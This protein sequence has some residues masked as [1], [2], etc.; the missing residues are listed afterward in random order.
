MTAR[1][2]GAIL[3]SEG[4]REVLP[5]G[6][7]AGTLRGESGRGL[8]ELLV[9]VTLIVLTAAAAIPRAQSMVHESRLR[10]AAFYLRGL[11]RQVRANAAAHARYEG[12]VFG[13]LNGSP[14]FS[15]HVDGN[16]NGIRRADIDRGIDPR[17]REPY[18]L[19][20]TF[21]GIHYG[22]L[23]TGA[24][25]PFFRGLQIGRGNIVS[26]SPLGSSTSGTLYLTNDYGL[27]YAVVILGAT[28]RVR[29]ARYRGGKWESM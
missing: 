21:P 16:S 27:V 22:S 5:A 12:L 15:I 24:P 29:V 19:G 4:R 26:F 13:D 8:L 25:V 10:G 28:G 14:A 20:D 6:R 9:A 17:V 2:G 23:P 3:P 7:F 18:R 11:L 1:K